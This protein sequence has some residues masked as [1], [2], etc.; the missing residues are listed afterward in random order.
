MKQMY[1]VNN[2]QGLIRTLAGL[3]SR[4]SPMRPLLTMLA[5]LMVCLF[6]VNE[7]AWAYWTTDKDGNTIADN[8][9]V[10]GYVSNSGSTYYVASQD[11][12]ETLNTIETGPTINLSGPAGKLTYTAKGSSSLTG[13][14]VMYFYYSYATDGGSNWTDTYQGLTTSNQGYSA[15]LSV[16]VNA[17]RFLTKTGS[18]YKKY[19]SGIKVEMGSYCVPET[20]SVAFGSNTYLTSEEKTIIYSKSIYDFYDSFVSDCIQWGINYKP[21]LDEITLHNDFKKIQRFMQLAKEENAV[22]T[23][24]ELKEE[25]LFL[26]AV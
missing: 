10:K 14:G 18:T 2:S 25:Y 15:D 8:T 11:S 26:K 6:G 12:Y 5:L 22:R 21:L 7:K 20:T 3:K 1:L 16:D 17:I 19:V 23:Y 4:I 24:E 9:S 13:T